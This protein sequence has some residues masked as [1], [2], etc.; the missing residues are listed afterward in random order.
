MIEIPV[1]NHFEDKETPEYE[2][3]HENGKTPGVNEKGRSE[4]EADDEESPDES[5]RP[6]IQ[7]IASNKPKVQDRDNDAGVLLRILTNYFQFLGINFV[8]HL[9]WPEPIIQMFAPLSVVGKA[10]TQIYS[11]DCLYYSR[12]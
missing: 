10:T 8:F 11:Y 2:E 3:H 9:S 1:D 12:T 4:D 7:P 6:V 5:E